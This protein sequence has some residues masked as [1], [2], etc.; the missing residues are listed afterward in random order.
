MKTPLLLSLLVLA[1]LPTPAPAQLPPQTLHFAH[2]Y[3]YLES[4]GWQTE[5]PTASIPKFHPGYFGVPA[6]AV[7][8]YVDFDIDVIHER[9]SQAQNYDCLYGESVWFGNDVGDENDC[10]TT[11][12]LRL[13][14]PSG[15]W[16]N[17]H[18]ATYPLVY[19]ALGPYDFETEPI[20]YDQATQFQYTTD[21]TSRLNT[22]KAAGMVGSG[23]WTLTGE[24]TGTIG[25]GDEQTGG[26]C[27][28]DT[29]KDWHSTGAT[30]DQCD[31]CVLLS[32]LDSVYASVH[33]VYAY[34]VP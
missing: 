11:S 10:A 34:T 2:E 16:L 25:Y 31:D 21:V 12:L 3:A 27:Y 30:C 8:A 29:S 13:Q 9:T 24:H 19:F 4:Y 23:S 28:A 18:A 5:T 20:S 22:T 14:V 32:A 15:S 17:E 7:L 6:N 26:S 33:V 1:F